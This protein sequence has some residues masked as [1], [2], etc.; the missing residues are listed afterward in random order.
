M[1]KI[2]LASPYGFSESGQYFMKEVMIPMLKENYEILNPWDM[3]P[4]FMAKF[5]EAMKIQDP[6][7]KMKRW[8][9]ILDSTPDHDLGM[10]DEADFL[11]AVL[12]GA[13][14]DSGV[15]LEVGYA[16]A[17]GKPML[18]YRSDTRQAG[19][20]PPLKVNVMIECCI[21]KTGGQVCTANPTTGT[22]ALDELKM[23]LPL[24]FK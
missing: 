18:G 19:E 8:W 5:A 23:A 24:T 21:R 12:D 3:I 20:I 4:E 1:K 17:K 15:A 16:Y 14:A 22:T 13:D 11:L 9:E 7:E 6:E 10:V 2:Y